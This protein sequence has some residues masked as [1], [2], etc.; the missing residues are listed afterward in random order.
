MV[1]Q[2]GLKFESQKTC[3]VPIARVLA[4]RMHRGAGMKGFGN[5]RMVEKV[6]EACKVAQSTRLGKLAL[7][8]VV[9]TTYDYETLTRADTVGERPQL[10]S[11]PFFR[12]L[13]SMVGLHRVKEQMRNLINLQLQNFDSELRGDKPQLI[14]LHRVFLGNPGTGKTTVA[15][16]YGKLLKE[17]GFLSDGDFI[18]VKP[19]DLKGQAVGEA[20][21]T[22]AS[23]LAQAKGKVLFIDEAYGLDPS[24]RQNGFGGEVIDALVEG[25]EGS[26]GSDMAVVLAGYKPQMEELFRNCENPGLKRR[27]NLEEGLVFEDFSDDELRKIL[28][29]LVVNASL[30]IDPSTL[31]YAVKLIAQKRRMD[32]FGNAGECSA[33]LD[34]A[35]MKLS[36]RKTAVTVPLPN[37]LI[38]KD[39]T[40]EE[41][42]A[43]KAKGAF[44]DLE[45]TD[46]IMDLI[47]ELEDTMLEAKAQGRDP[48]SI[49]DDLHMI[50]TGPPGTGKTTSAKRFGIAFKNLEL[51]PRSD[52]EVVTASNLISRYVGGTSNNV[53][54]AM[55]RAKGGILFIDEAYGWVS[56]NNGN[57]GEDAIQALLD[58]VTMPEF[59]GKLIVVLSGYADDIEKLFDVNAGFRSRFDKRRIHFPEWTGETAVSAMTKAAV[60][61]RMKLTAEAEREALRLFKILRSLPHWASARDFDTVYKQMFQKRARRIGKMMRER[62]QVV[63]RRSSMTPQDLAAPLEP[64]EAV[65]VQAAFESII[66]TRGGDSSLGAGGG[67]LGGA[68]GGG[69]APSTQHTGKTGKFSNA[70]PSASTPVAPQLKTLNA[71]NKA[72]NDSPRDR[73]VVVMYTA[74]WCEPSKELKPKYLKTAGAKEFANVSYYIVDGDENP[75]AMEASGA[76]AY[77]TIKL[78]VA[79]NCVVTIEGGDKERLLKE[80]IR[81]HSRKLSLQQE[82]AGGR[83]KGKAPLDSSSKDEGDKSMLTSAS[84]P[85]FGG[86]SGGGR[87]GSGEVGGGGG[88]TATAFK[89]ALPAP[90]PKMNV[91]VKQP[92]VQHRKQRDDGDDDDGPSEQDVWSALEEACKE[93]E[94]D[95]DELIILLEE[96]DFPADEIVDIVMRKT[97]CNDKTRIAAM[98]KEQRPTYLKATKGAQVRG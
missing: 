13:T 83:D 17:C 34:R 70:D 20:A 47:N 5:G 84:H 48:A 33:L 38:V 6:L 91:K 1:K 81:E 55:R 96:S 61:D 71:Y 59:Q 77:P 19:S 4:R 78:F 31:D 8:K 85:S 75:E 80:K 86:G 93:L 29:D 14:S 45:A 73:V 40:G 89:P 42:S 65:D 41:T 22:T 21:A 16:L 74:A 95:L 28:K 97:G 24:R 72:V 82:M 37:H 32:D 63:G 52:V 26:A 23:I 51:L 35:K 92:L 2:H 7:R 43:E 3:G 50:F 10:E 9:L 30:S 53:V 11:S 66:K 79:G 36:A 94:L 57:F 12:Q 69:S 68:V 88:H 44:A 98:L 58:N 15:R 46:H 90:K 76:K 60:R 62:Q 27:F 49:V 25:I 39:F 64:F 18:E 67:G 56:R 54:D 87:G